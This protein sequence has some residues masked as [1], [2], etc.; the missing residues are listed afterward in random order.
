MQLL[1]KINDNKAYDIVYNFVEKY[2]GKYPADLLE[3]LVKLLAIK[4]K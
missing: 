2:Q 3:E 1:D 4:Y